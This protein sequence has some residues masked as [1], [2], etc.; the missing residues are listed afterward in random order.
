MVGAVGYKQLAA[1]ALIGSFMNIPFVL[2]IGIT[3]AVSQMVS[4]AHGKN[5]KKLTSHYFYNG[6]WICAGDGLI[7]SLVL[8]L[9]KG[10]LFYVID[11]ALNGIFICMLI[12]RECGILSMEIIGD[13]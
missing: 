12:F 1:V 5:D 6:I 13:R 9:S 7:I 10:A 4:L 11:F 2:G 3:L 8:E